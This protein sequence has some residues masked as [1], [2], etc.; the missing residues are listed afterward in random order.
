MLSSIVCLY[1][2]ANPFLHLAHF[3]IVRLNI[4]FIDRFTVDLFSAHFYK[5]HIT[6]HHI[7]THHITSHH[8]TTHHNTSHH[9]TSHHITSHHI[10]THHIT[11][12]LIKPHHTQNLMDKQLIDPFEGVLLLRKFVYHFA[13]APSKLTSKSVA[14]HIVNK[15]VLDFFDVS[16]VPFFTRIFSFDS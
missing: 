9:N 15:E 1:E 8:I 6:S 2:Q 16:Q 3:F 12:P 5:H 13:A 7:A 11:L 10:T 14:Q 4:W